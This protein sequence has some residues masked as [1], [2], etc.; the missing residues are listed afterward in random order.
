MKKGLQFI[1]ILLLLSLFMGCGSTEEQQEEA[2]YRIYYVNKGETAVVFE[3]YEPAGTT[4]EELLEE[5]LGKLME[6]PENTEFRRVIPEGV[7]LLEYTLENGQL[8]LYFDAAY[9]QMGKVSEVLL[10]AAVVRTVCQLQGVDYVAFFVDGQSLLDTNQR[11]VGLMNAELFVENTGEQINSYNSVTLNLY[12]AN[13]SGDKLVKERDTFHYSSNMSLEK[14]VVEQLIQGPVSDYTYPCIPQ[15]TKLLSISTKDG[16]CYVNLD[17]GFLAQGYDVAEAV[18]VY[19]IVNS[20]V[21]LQNVNKV[22]ILI[23][24]ETPKVY[25]EKISFETIFERNMDLVETT[26]E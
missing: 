25:R 3:G 9:L 15:E 18:P 17:G 20:L 24:G 8:Y 7:Q 5:F 16:I 23:N 22:Q 12:F 21:E 10:R 26:K 13:A 6:T 19:A 1:L 2:A 4:T 11:P 14:L